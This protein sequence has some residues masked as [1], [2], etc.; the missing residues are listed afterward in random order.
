MYS[1]IIE[2]ESQEYGLYRSEYDG[3]LGWIPIVGLYGFY[4]IDP[5]D[6]PGVGNESDKNQA[7]STRQSTKKTG[8]FAGY[9]YS[10]WC[11]LRR[12]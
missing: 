6:N 1:T 5:I 9:G 8:I 4:A 3:G 11:C 12:E 7:Q 10:Y 2:I